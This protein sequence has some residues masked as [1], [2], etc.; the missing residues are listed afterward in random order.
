MI[1]DLL[2][3]ADEFLESGKDNLSKKRFNAAVSNFFKAIVILCDYLVYRDMKIIP[4]NHNERFSI[5]EKYFKEIYTKV[6]ELFQ[7]YTASYN[8]RLEEKD[9]NKL[10]NYAYELKNSILDKK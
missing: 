4:K 1:E 5:L 3:N 2:K 7:T 10:K 9:A 8:L 6:S